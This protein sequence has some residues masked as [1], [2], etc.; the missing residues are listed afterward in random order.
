M[1]FSELP[2]GAQFKFFAGGSILTKTGSRSYS[3]P[4][5]GQSGMPADPDQE[6][7]PYEPGES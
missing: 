7:I 6:V 1:T 2:I 4:Q 5:W 3:A